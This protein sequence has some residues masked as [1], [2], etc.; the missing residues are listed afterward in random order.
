MTWLTDGFIVG[1]RSDPIRT[2]QIWTISSCDFNKQL[3]N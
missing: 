2:D 1:A 3:F